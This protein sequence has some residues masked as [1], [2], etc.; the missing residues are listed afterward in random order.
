MSTNDIVNI[1]VTISRT[2]KEPSL[3]ENGAIISV[4]GTNLTAGTFRYC[5]TAQ[6]VFEILSMSGNFNE[7]ARMASTFFAQGKEIGIN[8]LELGVASQPT[9][10][11]SA[12]IPDARSVNITVAVEMISGEAT[13]DW[14]DG[15]EPTVTS[16]GTV[17][18]PNQ[19]PSNPVSHNYGSYENPVTMTVT[20]DIKCIAVQG[21]GITDILEFG[22]FQQYLF[23]IP[24]LTAVPE[25]LPSSVT[26][27][28]GM[29]YGC[30]AF[31]QNISGWDTTNVT[32]MSYMFAF[33]G[34]NQP[35]NNWNIANVT[36][37]S[38]MFTSTQFDQE[39]YSWNVFN[40]TNLE[41]M[42]QGNTVFNQNIGTWSTG[43]VTNMKRLFS[44][45]ST[46]DQNLSGWCVSLIPT[47]PVGFSASSA[48]TDPNKP[49]WG[50]CPAQF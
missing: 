41:S 19:I 28:A 9:S 27:T 11:L 46:F 47:E 38:F 3:Q 4:G 33:S 32:D 6:A 14:G 44:G 29:F 8:V 43:N 36:N 20:G 49:V 37:L 16:G 34:F 35:V 31:N 17:T 15:S 50:T 10:T 23:A 7:V 30:V 5:A 24:T 12:L 48:L 13:I 1:N 21:S 26:K 25:I 40:V 2:P 22:N 39:L 45:A 18:P 42:F